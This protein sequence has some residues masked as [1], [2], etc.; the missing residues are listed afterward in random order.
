MDIDYD[1]EDHKMYEIDVE[2][3]WAVG[4]IAGLVIVALVLPLVIP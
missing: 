1:I 4:L 2:F 3:A